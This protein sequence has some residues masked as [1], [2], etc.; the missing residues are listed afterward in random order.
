VAQ[1]I[2]LRTALP[3]SY[4]QCGRF[5]RTAARVPPG[6][7]EFPWQ[8]QNRRPVGHLGNLFSALL[9]CDSRAT[10][11]RSGH[12]W[13]TEPFAGDRRCRGA[14]RDGAPRRRTRPPPARPSCPRRSRRRTVRA[15]GGRPSGGRRRTCARKLGRG[16][17]GLLR[18]PALLP[19]LPVKPQRGAG[20]HGGSGRDQDRHRLG[21]N[22]VVLHCLGQLV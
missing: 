12:G 14:D 2:V 7:G 3:V 17:R 6:P 20:G 16:G 11:S 22:R 5:A 1:E 18:A 13:Q 8:R 15:T 4:R 10:D 19:R 9:R 21:K